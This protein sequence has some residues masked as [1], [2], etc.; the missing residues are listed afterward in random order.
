MAHRPRH[1]NKRLLKVATDYEQVKASHLQVE[2]A[3]IVLTQELH[4][5]HSLRGEKT[6][7]QEPVPSLSS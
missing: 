7:E 3:R 1:D 4:P 5:W 2:H 6:R